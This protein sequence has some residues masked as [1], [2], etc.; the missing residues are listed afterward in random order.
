VN[1]DGGA[2]QD[3]VLDWENEGGH[4]NSAGRQRDRTGSGRLGNPA[5]LITAAPRDEDRTDCMAC[6]HSPDTHDKIAR[7]FCD[8][9][10]ERAL[11]RGCIC[12][13]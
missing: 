4:S 3:A 2:L 11:T 12:R 6:S 1:R 13:A 9:T 10:V 7:R 5:A 8:A